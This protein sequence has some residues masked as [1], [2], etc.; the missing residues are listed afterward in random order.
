LTN[1]P[2]Y[3][4]EASWK[5]AMRELTEGDPAALKALETQGLEWGGWI[6]TR[7]YRFRDKDNVYTAAEILDDPAGM[8]RWGYVVRRYP[9]R[10]EALAGISD[11]LFREPLIERMEAR[12]A[13]GRALELV[14]ELRSA[15]PERQEAILGRLAAL[16]AETRERAEAS[17]ALDLFLEAAGVSFPEPLSDVVAP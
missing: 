13:V 5:A 3:D 9:E 6:G 16:R 8:V 1:P 14:A 17:R 15:P 12:L 4:P 10:I 11:P 7:N 2:A